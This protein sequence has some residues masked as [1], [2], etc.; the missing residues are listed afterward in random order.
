MQAENLYL[1]QELAQLKR[2]IFGSKSERFIQQDTEQLSLD[3]GVE[4]QAVQEAETE[5]LTYTRKKSSGQK[6][7]S[8]HLSVG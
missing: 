3:L 4:Q 8:L 1:K 7:G 6:K 2:M 5:E